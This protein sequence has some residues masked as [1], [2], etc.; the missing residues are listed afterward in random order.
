MR[1]TLRKFI[2]NDSLHVTL[3]PLVDG[4]VNV[5]YVNLYFF[6][7]CYL[8]SVHRNLFGY[9]V[10]CTVLEVINLL[11]FFHRFCFVFTI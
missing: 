6:C 9:F 1:F 11:T 10:F 3:M 8:N 4:I 5:F 2:I 7:G